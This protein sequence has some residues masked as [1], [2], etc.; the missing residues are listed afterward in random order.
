MAA[1]CFGLLLVISVAADFGE[2]EGAFALLS[3]TTAVSRGDFENQQAQTITQLREQNSKLVSELVGLQATVAQDG[4]MATST[5]ITKFMSNPI[6]GA[7]ATTRTS[8]GSPFLDD[9]AVALTLI[10]EVRCYTV[11]L[12]CC[13]SHSMFVGR[14]TV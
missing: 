12:G 13:C 4:A 14:A 10:P 3:D 11:V 5:T 6:K 1:R 2:Q 7:G 9:G 8:H